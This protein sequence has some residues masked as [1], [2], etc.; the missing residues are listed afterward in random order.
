M[1]EAWACKNVV[2]GSELRI[3]AEGL[4]QTVG[5]E[6]LRV[7]DLIDVELLLVCLV[8]TPALS[9]NKGRHSGALC[10]V[11]YEFPVNRSCDFPSPNQRFFWSPLG[12]NCCAPCL[13]S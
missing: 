3:L 11:L 1:A 6:R 10:D 4:T 13:L 8:N 12:T 2:R 7:T 5:A 9:E